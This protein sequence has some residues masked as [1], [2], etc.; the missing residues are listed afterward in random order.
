MT[1]Q[2]GPTGGTPSSESDRELSDAELD[3]IAGGVG[4]LVHEPVHSGTVSKPP[5]APPPSGPSTRS[6]PTMG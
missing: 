2:A 5:P 6:P 1:Q 4:G 3:G